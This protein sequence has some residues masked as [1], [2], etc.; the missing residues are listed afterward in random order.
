M[1]FVIERFIVLCPYLESSLLDASLYLHVTVYCRIICKCSIDACCH[2][3]SFRSQSC[4]IFDYGISE[5]LFKLLM[6]FFHNILPRS[7]CLHSLCRLM[8]S[9]SQECVSYYHLYM[10]FTIIMPACLCVAC[11]NSNEHYMYNLNA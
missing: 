7:E 11:T 1:S 2:N 5:I 8:M 4:A 3:Y 6:C 10:Y 9:K